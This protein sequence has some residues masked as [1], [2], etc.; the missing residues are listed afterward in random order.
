MTATNETSGL[1]LICWDD[2]DAAAAAVH[3]A[4]SILPASQ[5]ALVVFAY[6]PSESGGGILPRISAGSTPRLTAAEADAVLQRGVQTASDAGLDATGVAVAGDDAAETIIAT[7][8][9][10]KASMIVLGQG[11]RS[12]LSRTLLGS[13][14]RDVVRGTEQPAI[15]VSGP[16]DGDADEEPRRTR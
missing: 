13:V 5:R 15:I 1:P 9:E 4:A 8:E 3:G 6:L 10:R 12:Q 11:P 2:S 16:T 14:A 7:A